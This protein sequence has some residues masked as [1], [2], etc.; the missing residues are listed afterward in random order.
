MLICS[1]FLCTTPICLTFRLSV[2]TLLLYSIYSVALVNRAASSSYLC[3]HSDTD[4]DTHTTH[5]HTH[6]GSSRGRL[7]SPGSRNLF[8]AR[9]LWR[10]KE[11][12]SLLSALRTAAAILCPCPRPPA[13]RDMRDRESELSVW[14]SE[15]WEGERQRACERDEVKKRG[16]RQ[17]KR[18][19]S[20]SRRQSTLTQSVCWCTHICVASIYFRLIYVY[21]WRSAQDSPF[22]R[23]FVWILSCSAYSC[24]EGHNLFKDT[25]MNDESCARHF[26]LDTALLYC[27]L[28]A[29]GIRHTCVMRWLGSYV[30]K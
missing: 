16:H 5:T 13:G 6:T 4:T 18:T 21:S 25:R 30:E 1:H 10:R 12:V 2:R 26:F 29:G 14:E 3:W 9:S 20:L 7:D 28:T 17:I 27:R 8:H 15:F 22:S 24:L 23:L 11:Q 19:L